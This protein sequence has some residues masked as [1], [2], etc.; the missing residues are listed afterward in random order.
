MNSICNEYHIRTEMLLGKGSIERLSKASVL[1]FGIGGVGGHAIEA[2]ARSGV[3]K[4]TIV[5]HDVVTPS[6]LN[7]QLVATVKTIGMSKAQAMKERILEV[8]PE[9]KVIVREEFYLPEQAHLFDLKEYDYVL[10]AIDT[11]S[12]KIDLAVRCEKL[13]VPLISAM[14]AGNKTDPTR[15]EITDIYKT[16]VCPLAKVMRRELKARGVKHLKVV[17]SKEEPV[18]PYNP[19]SIKEGSRPSPGSCSFVPSVVGLIMAGETVREL[20]KPSEL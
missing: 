10:D 1:V 8:A 2:L 3:G 14:G 20:C 9:C 11:V 6:N 19:E 12:A 4:L 13:G 15:F 7:R 17:Y 18:L 16:S 5:D